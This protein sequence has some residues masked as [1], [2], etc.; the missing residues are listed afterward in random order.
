MLSY[1]H[2]FHAGNAADV[3]KHWVLCLLLAHLCK[4]DKPFCVIDTHAGDGVYDLDDASAQKTGEYKQGIASLW[5]ADNLPDSLQQYR[6]QVRRLNPGGRLRYYPGSPA[7]IRAMLREDDHAILLEPHSSAFAALKR[8]FS[9]RGHISV[10]QRDAFEGLPALL[11]P[12]A[13]R[14]LILIDPSYEIKTDYHHI[15]ELVGKALQKWPQAIVAVWYPVLAEGRHQHLCRAL[16]KL[17]DAHVDSRL[18]WAAGEGMIASGM[19]VLNPPWQ[20]K[21]CLQ[22][23]GPALAASLNGGTWL[24]R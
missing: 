21:E 10:Q 19:M 8:E 24:C 22:A 15:A 3:H 4:K 7:I 9:Q 2:A 14:G 16:A 12:Q 18:Q 13:R 20:L 23:D 17:T 11:P 1:R 6:E 5:E